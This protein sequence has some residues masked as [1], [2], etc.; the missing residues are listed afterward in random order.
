MVGV[1]IPI[2]FMIDHFHKFLCKYSVSV[3]DHGNS[4]ENMPKLCYEIYYFIPVSVLVILV[5][6]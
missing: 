6:H 5:F 1:N 4:E 3:F 2:L